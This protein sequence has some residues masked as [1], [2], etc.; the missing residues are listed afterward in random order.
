M[1]GYKILNQ[2]STYRLKDGMNPTY[3]LVV[4]SLSHCLKTFQ[5]INFHAHLESIEPQATP[6]IVQQGLIY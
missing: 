5:P 2:I 6:I 1:L 3:K 4:A